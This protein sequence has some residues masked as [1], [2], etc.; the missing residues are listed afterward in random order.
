MYNNILI[1]WVIIGDF[2]EFY[3]YIDKKK[4]GGIRVISNRIT[5]FV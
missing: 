2:D 5:I 1:F 4:K 3:D